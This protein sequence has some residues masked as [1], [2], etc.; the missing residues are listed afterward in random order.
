MMQEEPPGADTEWPDSEGGLS[1]DPAPGSG[2]QN[3]P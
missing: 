1:S 3:N 2:E